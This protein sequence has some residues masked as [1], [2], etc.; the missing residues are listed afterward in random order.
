MEVHSTDRN[1]S[2]TV[3]GKSPFSKVKPSING[4]YKYMVNVLS[5]PQV[6]TIFMALLVVLAC[7]NRPQSWEVYGIGFTLTPYDSWDPPRIQ[8]FPKRRGKPLPEMN[9][10]PRTE[11]RRRK[12]LVAR[13]P[14]KSPRL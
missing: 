1:W 7:I 5:P 13:A 12:G 2:A 11:H 14:G 9:F 4:L 8:S 6:I 10:P 3:V